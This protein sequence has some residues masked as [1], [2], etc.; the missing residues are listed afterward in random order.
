MVQ[1]CPLEMLDLLRPQV[2]KKKKKLRVPD[3]YILLNSTSVC[4]CVYFNEADKIK[5]EFQGPLIILL[6][7]LIFSILN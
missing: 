7:F 1:I 6:L 2:K 5:K 4:V 3:I